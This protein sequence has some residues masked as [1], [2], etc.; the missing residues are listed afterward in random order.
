MCLMWMLKDFSALVHPYNDFP[1]GSVLPHFLIYDSHYDLFHLYVCNHPLICIA[2]VRKFASCCC[3]SLLCKIQ[4]N[5]GPQ[6]TYPAPGSSLFT[7]S[8]FRH[9]GCYLKL[10][11]NC[12]FPHH[13]QSSFDSYV[14]WTT[15]HLFSNCNHCRR[16]GSTCISTDMN[17]YHYQRDMIPFHRKCDYY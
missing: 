16:K 17:A 11:H 14:F 13:I 9:T 15:L 1:R 8:P 2:F 3:V 5:F 12:F 4:F 10:S 7:L 6:T